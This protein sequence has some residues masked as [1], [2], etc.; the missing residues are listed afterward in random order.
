MLDIVDETETSSFGTDEG[1]TP[2]EALASEHASELIS[3]SLVCT[4]EV[5]NLP[6]TST[7]VTS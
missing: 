1:T 7:N 6:S 4:E 2:V 3:K 5:T